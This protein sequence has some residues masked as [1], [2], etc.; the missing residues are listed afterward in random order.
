MF[1][2][3]VVNYEY[4]TNLY[5]ARQWLESLPDTF[6]ADFEAAS[7]FTK[8]EKSLFQYRLDNYNL[9][10]EEKLLYN[11]YIQSDGLSHPS[12][13]VITHL[14]VA[15]SEDEG[16]VIICDTDA[17][18]E[19]IGLYL[20][21]TDRTQIWHNAV[22]DFSHI[23]YLTGSIPKNFIDTQ[24]LSRNMLNNA[25][26]SKDRTS[27]KY[28]MGEYYGDWGISKDSFTLEEMYNP[29]TIRYSATDATA[30]HKLYSLIQEELASWKI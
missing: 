14:S 21:T 5:Q 26:S 6:A 24:L 2:P 7:K 4:T 13:T 8:E 17:L 10:F 9:T 11:Q 23:Y 16:Y 1:N 28:L 27:L 3:I 12:L 18:R 20:I 22:Y 19:Y 29:K 25:D 15:W 30:T